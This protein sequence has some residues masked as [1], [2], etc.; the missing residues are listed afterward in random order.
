M[1][2]DQCK[3]GQGIPWHIILDSMQ[4]FQYRNFYDENSFLLNVFDNDESPATMSNALVRVRLLQVIRY[5]FKGL[6]KPVQLGEIYA[7]MQELG[8]HKQA[9]VLALEAFARQRLIV[10]W[11]NAQ[12]F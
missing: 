3:R 11:A 8:Y 10:T 7:D 1:L 6:Y 5:R 2:L 4:R 12:C 9:V